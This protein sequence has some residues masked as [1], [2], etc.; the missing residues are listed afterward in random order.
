M[1]PSLPPTKSHTAA[2]DIVDNDIIDFSCKMIADVA[3]LYRA[4][5]KCRMD[6]ITP[7]MQDG[8]H[9]FCISETDGHN[10]TEQLENRLSLDVQYMMENEDGYVQLRNSAEHRTAVPTALLD[11]FMPFDGLSQNLLRQHWYSNPENL[12]PRYMLHQLVADNH[13]K[14]PVANR[15]INID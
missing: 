5:R 14:R 7:Q 12:L 10:N 4:R 2:A 9:N 6:C 15:R 3:E 1:V 8:L 13:Y 11:A